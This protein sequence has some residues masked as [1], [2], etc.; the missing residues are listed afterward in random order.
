[1]CLCACVC[2]YVCICVCASGPLIVTYMSWTC[3]QTASG[4]LAGQLCV[5]DAELQDIFLRA[6][7]QAGRGAMK[8]TLLSLGDRFPMLAIKPCYFQLTGTGNVIRAAGLTCGG[9]IS[10]RSAAGQQAAP[11]TCNMLCCTLA[12]EEWLLCMIETG[13]GEVSSAG[14]CPAVILSSRNCC[15]I[16]TL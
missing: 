13:R 4:T 2:L 5:C 11:H 6:S 10:S 8:T 15:P 9:K 7:F 12:W 1:M 16:K 14:L 3:C